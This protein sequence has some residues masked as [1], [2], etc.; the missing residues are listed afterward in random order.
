MIASAALAKRAFGV[1]GR[2]FPRTS[3]ISQAVAYNLFLAF[4]PALLILV[5]IA[6]S[7]IGRRTSMFDL[8]ID[9]TDLLP[10][11]SQQ[12][13]SEFL[14]NRGP[15]AWKWALIGLVGTL[16]AGTQVMRLVMEGIHVIYGDHD[17]PGFWLRQL[18]SVLLLL[19]TITPL[20]TAASLGV[21]GR[22]LR[23]WVAY[24]LGKNQAVETLWGVFFHGTAIVFAMLGLTIIYR[25]AR[26][27]ESSLGGVLPGAMVA[28][29]LWWIAD[30]LFGFYV[31]RV[32]Y[33]VVYGGLAAVIG[34]LIWMQISAAIIFFGAAWNAES[35][36]IK[37]RQAHE[38]AHEHVAQT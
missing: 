14:V 26:P 23:R 9:M 4:F 11:G 34:L 6:T 33:N 19:I 38:Q 8:I 32:P 35:A 36:E 1:F 13:V 5:G 31:R 28:T 24:E 30:L 7:P 10:P 20:I 29:G 25:V 18:R 3:M 2:V 17:R 22:P 21:F 27:R 15:D 37:R 12:I 16:L